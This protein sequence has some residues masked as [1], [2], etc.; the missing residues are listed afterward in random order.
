MA[1]KYTHTNLVAKDWKKLSDF[2]IEVFD[3]KPKPP[4]R[5]LAGNWLDELTGINSAQIRG[6]HLS[7]P[8]F[9]QN[10]PTLEIFQYNKTME[11]GNKQ[12]NKEGFGHIAFS[13]D[14]VDACLQHLI[15]NGGTTVGQVV[16]GHVAGVGEIYLVYARDPEGNIIEIQKWE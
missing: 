10:G 2:Y 8:G 4:E 13:V 12:I 6:I 3:C 14:D 7:L 16:K 5:D 1:I 9:E 11:D 15:K